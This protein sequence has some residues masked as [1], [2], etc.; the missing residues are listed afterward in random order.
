MM[1]RRGWTKESIKAGDVVTIDG[2]PARDGAHYLRIREV[3]GADGKPIGKATD[4][5][6]E[7]GQ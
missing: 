2:W 1:T 3:K 7:M 6:A 4:V 5:T